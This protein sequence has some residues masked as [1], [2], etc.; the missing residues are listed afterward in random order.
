L[1]DGLWARE[2]S[3]RLQPVPELE[4]DWRAP[5]LG[6]P[7][8]NGW[9]PGCSG[10][11]PVRGWIAYQELRP[12]ALPRWCWMRS[13]RLGPGRMEFQRLVLAG[14]GIRHRDLGRREFQR[15]VLARIGMR[16]RDLARI[17][18]LHRD[19]ARIGMLHRDLA[20]RLEST[21]RTW[22]GLEASAAR[23]LIAWLGRC[24]A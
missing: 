2:C 4:P 19:L 9:V 24:W 14:I 10:S 8:A 7:A 17:G 3:Y 11:K 12:A 1:L 5:P 18:M 13:C 21:A 23:G 16:H 15:L 6:R 20:R 22:P